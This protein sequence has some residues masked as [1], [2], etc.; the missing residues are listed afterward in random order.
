[1]PRPVHPEAAEQNG[2]ALRLPGVLRSGSSGHSCYRVNGNDHGVVVIAANSAW[3]I[4][5]FRQGLIR[6]IQAEGYTVIVV[7]PLESAI[8]DRAKRLGIDWIT[9]D[10]KRASLNPVGDLLL[11]RSYRKILKG[12][13]P[14]AFFSFTIKANIYGC[15]AARWAGV[16]AAANVSGLGTVFAHG[17]PLMRLVMCMYRFAL[18][19]A[20]VV[21]FQN[22]DDLGLFVGSGVV[23]A[24]QARPLPGSGVDLQRFAPSPL[25]LSGP[26]FLLVARLLRDKGIPEYVEA[27]RS[28]R[29]RFPDA[30][31]QLLGPVDH[32]NP[33]AITR[34]E[35]DQWIEQGVV[36]YLGS[37]DDVR[38]FIE[39]ASAVVLPTNYRE[40]VPRSLLEAAAMARPIIG[41]R[42]P[43]CRDL[44]EEGIN[45]FLAEPRSASSLCRAM[46]E[47]L[48]MPRWR[49]MEMGRA[50][51]ATVEQRF[52]EQRVIDAYLD[53]LRT[54]A[55]RRT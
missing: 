18:A 24:E 47:F 44:V 26:T 53:V 20:E 39:A 11:L 52:S 2:C 43:G 3:N 21:F 14:H 31:F 15:L 22:R 10:L 40:G 13:S 27:S 16:P 1:V 8:R 25:P 17:G 41:T 30:R 55:H 42:M 9:V 33:T 6:A 5:N 51:R 36:E 46:E 48:R 34:T 19:R 23:R 45:G 28:L 37:T 38:P 54:L 35:L 29:S 12:I 49:Q 32:E 50:A 4:V 7:A